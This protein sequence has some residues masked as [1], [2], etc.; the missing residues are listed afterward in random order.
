MSEMNREDLLQLVRTVWEDRDP[1]PEGLVARMQTAAALAASSADLDLE[2]MLLVERSTEL[3]GARSAE[4]G[5][6]HG[7]DM[8]A[9]TLRFTHGE[10]DLLLRI[11]PDA[12]SHTARV[13]GWVVPPEPMTVRVVREGDRPLAVGVSDSGRFELIGLGR[14]L[15]HLILEPL[16]G[17]RPPFATPTFEL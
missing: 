11:A 16:D 10:V 12:G 13:D 6:D 4:L 15:V 14:G 7:A 17:S 5:A 3:A 8:A 1:M 9:Y 2:L